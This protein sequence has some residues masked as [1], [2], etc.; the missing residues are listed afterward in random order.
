MVG[1]G[2]Q[3]IKEAIAAM[4]DR[5][6]SSQP[7][8]AK[9]IE[10][11]YKGSLPP[12]FKKLLSV[13]LKKFTK[14]EKLVKVKNSFK[15]APAVKKPAASVAAGEQ[16]KKAAARKVSSKAAVTGA[17]KGAKTTP[18]KS[19]ASEAKGKTKTKRLSQVKTP[20]GMKKKKPSTPKKVAKSVKAVAAKKTTTKRVKTA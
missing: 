5:T 15:I 3:M 18:A 13:Q 2:F 11:K 4:K 16:P 17:E 8:I 20:T 6:G 7:A 12:N 9:F 1:F 10:E 19:G 14:S